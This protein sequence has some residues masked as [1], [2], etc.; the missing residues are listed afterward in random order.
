MAVFPDYLAV[1]SEFLSAVVTAPAAT[2]SAFKTVY[3]DTAS[4][5]VR[6][7]VEREGQQLYVLFLRER[8]GAYP[9]G[10]QGNIIVR[11]DATTNFI[12]GIKWVLSDDG[13]SWISLTPNN[14]RTIVEY[15]VG[16]SVV[17]SGLSVSSLLYYFFLQPFIHLHD[18][19]RTTLDWT[20]VLGEPGAAGLP[21]FAADI[22]ASRGSAAALVRS[23]LDFSYVSTNIAASSLRTALPEEET[24]PAFA[25]SAVMADG[26]E[27][28]K[29]KA[30]VWSAERGLPLAAATAVMLSRLADGSVFLGYVDSGDGRYPYKLVLF[31]YRTERGSYALF[32]FDAESRKAMDWGDLVRSRSDGYIRLIRLPAP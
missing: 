30:A 13:L 4:G 10:S 19:T 29:A 20:L 12:R 5:R 3:R 18:M 31:P 2:A 28:A 21:R 17:R 26:R 23:S 11:R 6:V 22:A 7:S 27:T 8:D 25:Q 14:E 1:R 16:G 24:K 9:Y 15:V 32:A